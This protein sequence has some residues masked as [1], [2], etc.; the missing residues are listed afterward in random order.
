MTGR[1]SDSRPVSIMLIAKQESAK[2]ET[3]K[4][5]FGTPTLEYISDLTSRGLIPYRE[6]IQSGTLR[7]LVLLDLVRIIAHGRGV[8]ERTLQ[9]LAALMEEGETTTSDAGEKVSWIGFPRIGVLMGIT[10]D[11]FHMKRA[12]WRKTGFLSRFL[13]VSFQYSDR[14][15]LA[16]HNAISNGNP[17]PKPHVLKLPEKSVLVTISTEHSNELSQQAQLIGRSMKTYGFRYQK[18]MRAL[19]K[20]SAL[21]RNS[22]T[23]NEEDVQ[24]V[25]RWSEFFTLKEVEL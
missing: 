1:L 10:T 25:I 15:V 12:H 9:T 8:T 19:A 3:L 11:F 20:A 17:I 18:A 23:V 16:I 22:P 24:N 5:F 21:I 2:T 6:K 7:H 14:T 13:P 4:H